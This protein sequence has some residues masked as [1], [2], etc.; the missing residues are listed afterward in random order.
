MERSVPDL[1]F[2]LQGMADLAKATNFY[3]K[4]LQ[5]EGFSEQEAMVFVQSWH[6]YVLPKLVDKHLQTQ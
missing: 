1:E 5:E 2:M 4:K 3:R 6:N